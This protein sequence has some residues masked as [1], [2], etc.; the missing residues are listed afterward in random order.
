MFK[1]KTIEEI[2]PFS[3]YERLYASIEKRESG[4]R[5]RHT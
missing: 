5:Q 1:K 3:L 4:L 2:R